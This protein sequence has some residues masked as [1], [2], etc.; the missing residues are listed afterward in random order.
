M[1][2]LQ[3]IVCSN[4]NEI[5]VFNTPFVLIFLLLQGYIIINNIVVDVR[6]NLAFLVRFCRDMG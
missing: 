3:Y 6:L 2:V 5:H 4:E 1:L